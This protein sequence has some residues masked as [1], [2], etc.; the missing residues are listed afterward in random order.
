MY[1][2]LTYAFWNIRK[3]EWKNGGIEGREENVM[4]VLKSR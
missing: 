1:R 4:S 2:E 3:T